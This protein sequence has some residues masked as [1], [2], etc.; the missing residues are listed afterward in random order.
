MGVLTSSD[1][2]RDGIVAVGRNMRKLV[3][4]HI[5]EALVRKGNAGPPAIRATHTQ[6]NGMMMFYGG[7]GWV[8]TSDP[9]LVRRLR[10]GSQRPSTSA[11]QA[12]PYSW[13]IT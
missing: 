4:E 11:D 10:Q 8:R 1:P 12:L 9:P 2:G 6:V 13:G 3:I 5:R 7:H